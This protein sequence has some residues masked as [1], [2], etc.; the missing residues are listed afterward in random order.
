MS[1]RIVCWTWLYTVLLFSFVIF[2]SGCSSQKIPDGAEVP[3]KSTTF[4]FDQGT[5]PSDFELFEQ[6][7]ISP[8][9]VLDVIYQIKRIKVDR[10]PITLYHTVSVKFVNL[11]HL[12]TV[13]E[14]LPTGNI[15]LPYIGDVYVLGKTAKE[16]ASELIKAYSPML[17]KPQIYVTI[18][19]FNVRIDQIRED[20]HTAP[21]GLSKLI[22]VRP[23]GIA[24][25]PLIGS[26]VVAHKTL[27]QVHELIQKRYTEF[28]PGMKADLFL[29]E[30]KGSVV[31]MIGEVQNSGTYKID[32]PITVLQAMAMAG[33]HTENAELESVI[34]F[35]QHEG[36]RIATSL[37]IEDLLAMKPNNAF[38]Y[39]RPDDVIYIPKTRISSLAVLMRQIADVTFFTGWG[40]S[41]DTLKFSSSKF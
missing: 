35:R 3:I 33:G 21:R 2:S 19:N 1:G 13:Q 38:F 36:Q 34:V 39:I 29:H 27:E 16:L 37:N 30:K 8:G 10:F 23:D 17:R 25:F 28:L 22:Y 41:L 18:P 15:T 5:Y 24:T 32:K 7:L 26:L 40:V 11:S 12:D 9:D 20:L 31:Y 4:S 6:Y 14:V